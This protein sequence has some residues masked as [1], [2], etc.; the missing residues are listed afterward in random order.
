M[1]GSL[2]A[3]RKKAGSRAWEP[4]FIAD[5]GLL[6]SEVNYVDFGYTQHSS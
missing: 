1:N 6:T 3:R 4:A 5:R 2:G